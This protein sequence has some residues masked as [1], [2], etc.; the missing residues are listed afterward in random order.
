MA[1]KIE[2]R[3][4]YVP[5][6][7]Y[8]VEKKENQ[9]DEL[10]VLASYR[11]G[12]RMFYVSLHAGWSTGWGHGCVLMGFQN[13]LTDSIT[14]DV[15]SSPRNSRKTIDE[16]YNALLLAKD[17][18]AWLFDQRNWEELKRLVKDVALYGYTPGIS[19]R[20]KDLKNP[21][22]PTFT[23]NQTTNNSNNQ[24]TM[25]KKEMSAQDYVGKVIIVGDNIATITIKSVNAEGKLMGE[26][27]KGDMPAILMPLDLEQMAT[28]LE[29]GMYKF[30]N[31]TSGA[32]SA[33]DP[34]NPSDSSS[35]SDPSNPSD[36]SSASDPSDDVEEVDDVKPDPNPSAKTVR[37][38]NKAEQPKTEQPKTEQPKAEPKRPNNQSPKRLTFSTYEN[39]KGKTCAKITG[40][41]E[42]DAAVK[43]AITLHASAGYEKQKDGSKVWQLIFGPRY[44]DAAKEVCKVL[45]AGKSLA[46]AQAI[47]EGRTE[48]RAKQREEWKAKREEYKEGKNE[49]VK[50]GN[51]Y[52]ADDVAAMLKKI[53]AGG[54]IP[55]EIRKKM[56]A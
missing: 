7:P 3:T 14:I 54:D 26:Y 22:N 9:F 1:S 42:D 46:E 56:S 17:D 27:K 34:S 10:S 25:A 13:P 16:M 43:E 19:Q 28:Y 15:K 30:A 5:I 21:Q 36:S 6:T 52:S 44:A 24:E 55:E 11:E 31:E 45:N 2:G 48:E 49:Q 18:I 40:F 20:M 38:E 50:N 35:A 4:F 51:A 33:S 41:K 23:S 8:K 29:K 37:M 53:M 39:R 12:S 32:S 47:I